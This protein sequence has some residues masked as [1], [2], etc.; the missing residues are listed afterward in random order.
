MH[1][2]RKMP[3]LTVLFCGGNP[4]GRF[5]WADTCMPVS[6]FPHGNIGGLCMYLRKKDDWARSGVRHS[7]TVTVS[8]QSATG[9]AC[10]AALGLAA[11]VG[12]SGCF[13]GSSS[14]SSGAEAD[15]GNGGNGAPGADNGGVNGSDPGITV[16]L[17][18]ANSS[19]DSATGAQMLGPNAASL[20]ETGAGGAMDASGELVVM[21][22]GF[23]NADDYDV[24][25][26]VTEAFLRNMESE[27]LDVEHVT[28][29][30]ADDDFDS[31]GGTSLRPALSADGHHVVFNA[32]RFIG[33]VEQVYLRNLEEQETLLV[34]RDPMTDEGAEAG[35]SYPSISND[36]SRIVFQSNADLI[37]GGEH[38]ERPGPEIGTASQVYL[39]DSD[40][41]EVVRVSVADGSQ[42]APGDDASV[43]AEIS[44]NGKYVVFQSDA[45]DLLSDV[46]GE[47]TSIFLYAIADGSL[48]VLS[49]DEDGNQLDGDL[50]KPTI[51]NDGERVVFAGPEGLYLWERGSGSS[52]VKPDGEELVQGLVE[53]VAD[54]AISGDGRFV[55]YT[56]ERGSASDDRVY[57]LDLDTQAEPLR[58]SI[59]ADG[60][61]ADSNAQHPVISEDGSV[62]AFDSDATNLIGGDHDHGDQVD[63]Y[64]AVID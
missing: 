3:S 62:V 49:V 37:D 21:S 34:S 61:D 16:E 29:R 31:G 6:G 40:D 47:N 23:D 27:G 33:E 58:V 28:I 57:R 43:Y 56:H 44:G 11:M 4:D 22:G 45:S 63:V 32:S 20:V 26:G 60:T 10:L 1:S 2:D 51:D 8:W 64:R 19:G 25:S 41:D 39:Y 55:A 7:R 17:V 15:N 59:A 52:V 13:G 38:E 5:G 50:R 12:L 24:A 9:R 14:G 46:D 48:E 36:G 35:S 53:R 18:S 30:P 54:P 42:G